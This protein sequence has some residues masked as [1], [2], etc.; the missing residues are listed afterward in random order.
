MRST[1][2]ML[3][4]PGVLTHDCMWKVKSLK[5][6]V[7]CISHVSTQIYDHIAQHGCVMKH[8]FGQDVQCCVSQLLA[9]HSCQSSADARSEAASNQKCGCAWMREPGWM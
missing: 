3:A 8:R 9:Q 2:G 6:L 4:Q 7:L 5:S 1:D